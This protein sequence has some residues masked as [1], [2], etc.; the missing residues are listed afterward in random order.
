MTV[1]LEQLLS[2]A[3]LVPMGD[4]TDKDCRW[5]LNVMLWGDPGIGKSDRIDAASAMVGLPPRTVYAAT[6]Q[7]EDISGAAFVNTS[8]ALAMFE[9]GLE[10][11]KEALDGDIGTDGWLMKLASP[12]VKKAVNAML[13]VAKRYG[14]GFTSLEPLLPGIS[15]LLI[16]QQG[17]LFLDELSCA[18]PAVQGAYLGVVLARRVGG[19]KL[20]PQVRIVAAANPPNS[21]AG[22]WELEPPMANRF[23]H[24]AVDIPSVEAWGDWLITES[25]IK[26]DAIEDGEARVRQRWNDEWPVVKGQ[27][28]GFM[29]AVGRK[30]LHAIP[31]EGNPARGRAWPSPRT[32]TF[33]ARAAATCRCLGMSD[34]VR[35]AFIE[36]CVGD[37]AAVAFAAWVA[38]SDLPSPQEMLKNGWTPDKKRLDRT[39]AAYT[40]LLSYVTSRTSEQDKVAIAPAAWKCIAQAADEGMLDIVLP[41]AQQLVRAGLDSNKNAEIKEA[42]KPVLVRLAKAQM[43][44]YLTNMGTP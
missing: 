3:F 2:I 26:L 25:G 13:A 11:L 32:W 5:G 38:N 12:V 8:K 23:C 24:F 39:V 17:V 16:D 27:I 41:M 34:A 35:D 15:D 1:P 28:V 33:A 22:G 31:A 10:S 6:T 21:A 9:A 4:P 7:P 37:G 40:G 29:R 19:R 36:G 30:Q 43:G 14:G 42:A 18:R 44:N 20:P